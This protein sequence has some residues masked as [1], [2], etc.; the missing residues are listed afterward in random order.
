MGNSKFRWLKRRSKAAPEAPYE[1]PVWLGNMSNGEFFKPQTERDR[2]VRELILQKCD[3]F[4]RKKGM[5]RREFMASSMGMATTLSVLNFAS[6]CGGKDGMMGSEA[7]EKFMKDAGTTPYDGGVRPMGGAGSSSSGTSGGA[8]AGMMGTSSGRAGSSASS[9]GSSSMMMDA[10]GRP[11][12]PSAGSS[13]GGG[14]DG[15]FMIDKNMCMDAEHADMLFKRDYFILDFQT[16]HTNEGS[17]GP[18]FDDCMDGAE[19]T[20]PD[21]YV[22]KIF[23]MSDT[24]VAVLSGL[25]AMIDEATN[26]LSGFAFKNEDMRNSRDRVNKAARMLN[27]MAGERMVAHCQISP[28]ANPD[29]NARMMMENKQKYDTRG[30]KC[31]PPTEGGWFLHEND[32]FIKTAIELNE[33]LVCLHKGF[34]FQGWSRVHAN[35][36]P[37]VG[38]VALRYPTVNFVVYHSAYDS[39]HTEGPFVA[40]PNPDDGGTDRLWKVVTD[41]QLANKNVYAEM[42]SA[43]AMSMKDP[44]VAQ[45]YIGKAIK[46]MGEDRVVWGSECVW[47]GCPQNQIEAMK[48]FKIS[49]EFQDMFGYADYTDAVRRKVFGLNGAGLYRVDPNACRYDIKLSQLAAHR[50]RLDEVWGPRR[51]ALYNPPAIRTWRDYVKLGEERKR[52][53][54]IDA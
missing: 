53:G 22:R 16:H 38:V 1:T 13:G 41:N 26:D 9:A 10:A 35:P 47:F 32:G 6:G 28:K 7:V 24:T 2:R 40:D 23:E 36:M 49:T 12:T 37:D 25:P 33:P 19:C 3:D 20:S 34:P 21:T 43:W 15:G 44:V 8:T 18:V 50:Q 29:A 11:M 45:H 5:D 4:A 14:S 17:G 30:W 31:Y 42:G 52:R 48:A 39:A 54:E 51:H 27:P 46:Y